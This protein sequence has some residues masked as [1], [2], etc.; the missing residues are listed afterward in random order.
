MLTPIPPMLAYDNHGV[1]PTV[2]DG[3]IM[4]PKIDGVRWQVEITPY[5][6]R[7][8]IG[9]N[10]NEKSGTHP[11][12]D[13]ALKDLP[14]GTVLD[15]ELYD[16]DEGYKALAVFDVLMVLGEDVTAPHGTALPQRIR[17]EALLSLASRMRSPVRVLPQSAVKLSVHEAWMRLGLEGSVVKRQT[18]LYV[19]GKR[20][21]DWLKVKPQATAEATVVGWEWGKGAGNKHLCGALKIRLVDNDVETTV[22][23]G[24]TPDE[25]DLYAMQNRMLEFA[26]HGLFP[27]TGKPRHPVFKRWRDDR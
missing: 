14:V 5:G 23:Y 1:L 3:W 22:G 11:E 17:R 27:E 25:A 19:P 26:H 4:E 15:G 9:R 8:W 7:S 16:G 6:V 24:C 2:G 10:G 21:R 12:I 13:E 20:S 18:G